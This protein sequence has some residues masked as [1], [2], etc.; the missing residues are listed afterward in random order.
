MERQVLARHRT[1]NGQRPSLVVEAAL[2]SSSSGPRVAAQHITA[3][4]P[5]AR[6]R[7]VVAAVAAGAFVAAGQTIDKGAVTI[8][9]D[10]TLVASSRDATSAV[11]LNGPAP[12]PEYLPITQP[13]SLAETEAVQA[14]AGYL[15]RLDAARVARLREDLECLVAYAR[16]C[17]WPR[18][19]IRFLKSFLSDF[20]ISN[21]ERQ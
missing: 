12:S 20:G 17:K 21:G 19:M 10:A 2:R 11:G 16:Q 8:S 9:D 13:R 5:T 4:S 6:G 15:Q 14:M 18:E 7:V 3:P 1:P